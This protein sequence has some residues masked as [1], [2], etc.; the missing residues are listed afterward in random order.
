M[1]GAA[2]DV[3]AD[4]QAGEPEKPGEAKEVRKKQSAVEESRQG[5]RIGVYRKQ[6]TPRGEDCGGAEFKYRTG[7]WV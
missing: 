5:R 7:E 6:D 4:A 1:R 3:G 2:A